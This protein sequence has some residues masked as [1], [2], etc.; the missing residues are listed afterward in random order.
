[1]LGT[2]RASWTIIKKVTFLGNTEYFDF[3]VPVY[4]NYWCGGVFHHNCGKT[5][6]ARIVQ[7]MLNCSEAD[8]C[9]LNIADVRGIDTIRSIRE[10]MHLAPMGGDCRI[11]LLDECQKMTVDA[12]NAMLKP[13]E[14]T[15]RHVYF[16]LAT[17]EPQKLLQTI[18]TRAT[19]IKLR[20]V[21]DKDMEGL[22]DR[23]AEA[24]SFRLTEEVRDKIVGCSEGSPRKAL[25]LLEQV[26]RLESEEEQLAAV[27]AGVGTKEG[28]DL[29]RLLIKPKP[30]WS[31]VA[32]VLKELDADP[33]GVRRLVLSY[34]SSVM[35]GGGNLAS[36]AFEVADVF[37]D[38]LYDSGKAGLVAACWELCR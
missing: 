4:H 7:R 27:E 19:E 5:T 2:S 34:C 24:E 6:I 32:A 1:M 37:R 28:I 12:M 10:R 35:V 16:V 33:E 9:E 25:V 30:R 31:E 13:L 14:D 17:T 21:R 29:A 23:T 22:L 3:H 36:R 15:P 20:A 38:N 11:W 18:R 26:L 8:F